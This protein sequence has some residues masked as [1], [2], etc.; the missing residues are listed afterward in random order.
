MVCHTRYSMK[1]V[2]KSGAKK[3]TANKV[4]T[5]KKVV[6]K[7][8]QNKTYYFQIRTYKTVDGGKLYSKWSGK[9]TIKAKQNK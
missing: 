7:L 3:V 4:K 8:K 9:K 1:N 5:T 2:F 6:K